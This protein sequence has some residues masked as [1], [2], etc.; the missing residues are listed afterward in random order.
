MGQNQSQPQPQYQFPQ[1]VPQSPSI[2]QEMARQEMARQEMAY[3]MTVKIPTD[4]VLQESNINAIIAKRIATVREE[5]TNEMNAKVEF[6]KSVALQEAAA[7]VAA[8]REDANRE[9]AAKVLE[10]KNN[11]QIQ[12]EAIRRQA[13][14]ADRKKKI[15]Y[16]NY[17]ISEKKNILD[18]LQ[19]DLKSIHSKLAS[20]DYQYSAAPYMLQEFKKI[21]EQIKVVAGELYKLSNELQDLEQ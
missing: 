13:Q 1:F 14:E 21:N 16:L 11:C 9:I 5:I 12:L 7:K 20:N 10:A 3:R 18:R 8:V 17:L 19:T 6:A 2:N 15:M 4:N